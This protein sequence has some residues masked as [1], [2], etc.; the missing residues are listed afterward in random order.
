MKVKLP[1]VIVASC[2]ASGCEK[3]P[4]LS[5]SDASNQIRASLESRQQCY[6]TGCP[7]TCD[8]EINRVS[9]EDKQMYGRTATIIAIINLTSKTDT[10]AINELE[11]YTIN[12]PA[13]DIR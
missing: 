13:R 7:N 8:W 4:Q 10:N 12:G 9:I 5:D 6:P 2:V 1:I 11:C 3:Q